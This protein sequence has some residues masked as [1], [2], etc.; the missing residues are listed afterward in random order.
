LTGNLYAVLS[1][2]RGEVTSEDVIEGT[3][4]FVLSAYLPVASS[5][6][7]ATELLKR[8]SGNAVTPQLIFSHWST[9]ALDPFWKPTTLEELEDLGGQA[10]VPN[11]ARSY[12][13]DVRRRKGLPLE[14]KV[15][16]SAEKQRTLTKNK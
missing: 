6:G 10:V 16:V 5:F 11:N 2:R 4:L 8:T 9:M 12:I 7:F 1:R 14:E 3:N 15:V 13:N